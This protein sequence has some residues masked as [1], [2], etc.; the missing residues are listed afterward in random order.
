MDPREQI[1]AS[2]NTFTQ[3][4]ALYSLFEYDRRL[5][6][7]S[8]IK[9]EETVKARAPHDSDRFEIA[10]NLD[11]SVI[12]FII[13]YS[14]QHDGERSWLINLFRD[15]YV[16]RAER[17]FSPVQSLR[18]AMIPESALAT[19]DCLWNESKYKVNQI[20]YEADVLADCFCC[21]LRL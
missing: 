2:I 21:D 17:S 1:F 12:N 4:T 5:R 15:D 7:I 14:L 19:Y 8:S 3:L 10:S 13:I 18:A 6:L 16:F 20:V 11:W 9:D